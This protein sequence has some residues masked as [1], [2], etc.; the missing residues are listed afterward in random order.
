ML[1]IRHAI[2]FSQQ[3]VGLRHTDGVTYI[4]GH[5]NHH[6]FTWKIRT[7]F[8]IVGNKIAECEECNRCARQISPHFLRYASSQRYYSCHQHHH[9]PLNTSACIFSL[10]HTSSLP[11][12]TST[13]TFI[14]FTLLKVFSYR[15][16][17]TCSFAKDVS[18]RYARTT[19]VK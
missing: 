6:A 17:K 19:L 7:N 14:Y 5:T 11:T 12:A 18:L 10:H 1:L 15:A 3:K 4:T 13:I 9:H 8:Q 2:L 16:T